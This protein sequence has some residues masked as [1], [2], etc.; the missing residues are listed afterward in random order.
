MGW[1]RT[2][3]GG[4]KH[5]NEYTFFNPVYTTHY[6]SPLQYSLVLI[7]AIIPLLQNYQLLFPLNHNLQCD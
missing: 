7:P 4:L 5:K 3:S 2:E 1:S 6:I